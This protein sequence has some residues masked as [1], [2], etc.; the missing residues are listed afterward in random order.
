MLRSA[1]SS[2]SLRNALV[3][4]ARSN[5]RQRL[6]KRDLSVPCHG[7]R[8]SRATQKLRASRIRLFLLH[9]LTFA[10][11]C[12][13]RLHSRRP[14]C[15]RSP[16]FGSRKSAIC[17]GVIDPVPDEHASHACSYSLA[18]QS[19]TGRVTL[20][21]FLRAGA[22]ADEMPSALSFECRIAPSHRGW[23]S[24]PSAERG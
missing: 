23:T 4:R 6:E 19:S 5:Q 22:R 24:S 21:I 8:G 9:A 14:S 18:A 16:S 13:S 11:A 3:V 10:N 12:G 20:P 1:S 17:A 15:R 7:S 2:P